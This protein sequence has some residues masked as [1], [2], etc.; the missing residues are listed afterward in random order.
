[1]CALSPCI[2]YHYVC[3]LTM[4][5]LPPCVHSLLPCVQFV[6]IFTLTNLSPCVHSLFAYVQPDHLSPIYHHVCTL[7]S[8]HVYL[9][10]LFT[11]SWP[12][13]VVPDPPPPHPQST[14]PKDCRLPSPPPAKN[15]AEIT[16]NM[17]QK[18]SLLS[19]IP[20]PSTYYSSS[21][22][23]SIDNLTSVGNRKI[24]AFSA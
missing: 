14:V 19:K 16:A 13:W 4:Y 22:I 5:N 1:M 23:F 15:I 18:H 20:Q 24:A 12:L 2:I 8:R 3:T 10:S 6:H 9:L 17:L 7:L 21:A 11:M